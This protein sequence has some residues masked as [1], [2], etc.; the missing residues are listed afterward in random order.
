MQLTARDERIIEWLRVVRIADAEALRWVLAATDGRGEP[1]S[2]RRAQQW[3]A[4]GVD[5]GVIERARPIFRDGSV[6]W[7]SHAL[8]GRVGPNLFRATTRHEVA[9]AAVSARFLAAGYTWERDVQPRSTKE[10]AAD[11]IAR[12]GDRAER[13]EVELTVKAL[14]RYQGILPG[15]GRW[16]TEGVERIVYVGTPAAMRAVGREADKWLHPAMRERLVTVP[17]LDERGH[18]VGSL[19]AL[20]TSS[21]QVEQLTRTGQDLERDVPAPPA[22]TAPA[23]LP[24]WGGRD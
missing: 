21:D 1:V 11:G 9:V 14:P 12:R 13:V 22:P 7:L 16:L 24:V 10:H 18:I 19:D 2:V 17:A 15:H 5:A 8:S 20:W 23:T 4:R 6:V 3:I